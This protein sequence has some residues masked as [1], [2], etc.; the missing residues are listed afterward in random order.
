MASTGVMEK[1]FKLKLSFPQSL[2]TK[3]RV[4][5]MSNHAVDH[6]PQQKPFCLCF[7]SLRLG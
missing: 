4:G 3:R 7:L 2:I 6:E 5:Q 1:V